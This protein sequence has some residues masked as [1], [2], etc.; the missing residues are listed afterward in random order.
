MPAQNP[1]A[2]PDWLGSLPSLS[3]GSLNLG[4]AESLLILALFL[5]W[6]VYT[7]VAA[8]HWVAYGGYTHR[9]V[10]ALAVHIVLSVGFFL[11]AVGG[12]H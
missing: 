8:Y 7:A 4:G 2:A 12:I 10:P 5:A 9:G 3:A 6:V 1:I 11:Y